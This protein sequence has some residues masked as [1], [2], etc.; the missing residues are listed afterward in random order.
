MVR[1]SGASTAPQRAQST[2][3]TA[4]TRMAEAYG[5]RASGSISSQ[6][7]QSIVEEG[8]SSLGPWLQGGPPGDVSIN[9]RRSVTA[10]WRNTATAAQGMP[11]APVNHAPIK[12]LPG[13]PPAHESCTEM[14]VAADRRVGTTPDFA[15]PR[16]TANSRFE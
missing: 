10:C 4:P 12:E 8:D 9:R 14:R 1:S 2:P 11:E 16:R 7:R 13:A 15:N 3:A 6:R 5:G